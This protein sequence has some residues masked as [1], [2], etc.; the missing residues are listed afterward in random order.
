M[1][2]FARIRRGPR[3]VTNEAI[4]ALLK[5]AGPV[6]GLLSALWSTTQKITYEA[7]GGIKRLTL[8]GRV[9]IGI[10]IVSGAISILALGLETMIRREQARDSAAREQ[11]RA[12]NETAKA[13]AEEARQAQR[14]AERAQRSQAE[15]LARLEADARESKRFLEQRFLILGAAAEQQR[16][17][18]EI[19]QQVAREANRR[20]ADAARSFAEFGRINYPLRSVTAEVQLALNLDGVDA[21]GFWDRIA[22][23]RHEEGFRWWQERHG[24]PTEVV[25]FDYRELDKGD[26][27]RGQHVRAAISATKMKLVFLPPEGPVPA[28]RGGARDAVKPVPVAAYDDAPL[29][30]DIERGE[31][32]ADI[33]ARTI[34]VTFV[35]TYQPVVEGVIG[36]GDKLSLADFDRL[37]PILTVTRSN[38]RAKRPDTLVGISLSANGQ[39]RFGVSPGL[40]I[41]ETQ[42]FLLSPGRGR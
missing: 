36:T 5:F 21:G 25:T 12:L 6:V 11:A 35:G 14:R 16:R 3:F 7:E 26:L 10:I 19:S 42:A 32:R 37:V 18:A 29:S 24:E 34:K 1:I 40:R 8:Q 30:L 38:F 28:P 2:A 22:G 13:R 41:G 4:L 39:T 33:G 23:F 9:M 31:V 17:D 15:A 27:D 20:L